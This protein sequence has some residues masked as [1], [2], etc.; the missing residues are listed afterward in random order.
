MPPTRASSRQ[1][2]LQ[3]PRSRS[4]S[5]VCDPVLVRQRV[6]VRTP[7]PDRTDS[8]NAESEER[9]RIRRHYEE[10]RAWYDSI[11]HTL[12]GDSLI[13]GLLALFVNLATFGLLVW[14]CLLVSGRHA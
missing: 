6:R 8:I 3:A 4:S 7:S 11:P 10:I 1:R 12:H 13:L 5:P 2:V 9:R 14:L